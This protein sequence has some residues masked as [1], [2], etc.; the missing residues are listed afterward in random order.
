[1]RKKLYKANN[2]ILYNL[3]HQILLQRKYLIGPR[4]GK[5]FLKQSYF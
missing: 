3:R 2:F 5:R 4:I 1:M